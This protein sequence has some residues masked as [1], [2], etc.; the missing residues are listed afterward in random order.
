MFYVD[1]SAVGWHELVGDRWGQLACSLNG[2]DRL[3]FEPGHDPKPLKPDGG[4]DWTQV[5][6]I[7]NIEIVDYL[8]TER[9]FIMSTIKSKS[10]YPHTPNYIT[11]LPLGNVIAEKMFEMGIDAAELAKRC[12]LP[13]ETIQGILKVEIP[14]TIEIADKIEK[15]TWMP[16]SLLM[17]FEENYR[18]DV[19]HSKQHPTIPAY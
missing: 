19:E 10:S 6:A 5:T 18:K 3:V 8:L 11:L 1:T 16:A 9:N 14:L 17:R 15:A 4:L 2:L 12:D 7:V 13:E